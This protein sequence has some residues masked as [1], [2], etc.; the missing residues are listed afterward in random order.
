MVYVYNMGNGNANDAADL[1]EYL[2]SPNNGSNPNGG[3][4]W[5]AVRA[6]NGHP[7]P[8]GIKSFEIGNEM[9]FINQR[10]WMDGSSNTNKSWQAKYAFGDTVDFASQPVVN[11]GDWRTSASRSDGTANQIKYLLL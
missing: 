3:V 5:A 7:E 8:Y 2:N 1:I 9:F 11:N 6:A 10:Y 4:D